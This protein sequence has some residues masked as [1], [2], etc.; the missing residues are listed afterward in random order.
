MSA[1]LNDEVRKFIDGVHPAVLATIN[2]DGGPQTS[3]VW[4]MRDG[5]DL[6]ISTT[7]GLRKDKNLRRDPRASVLVLSSENDELYVEIRGTATVTE[8]E[9]RVVAQALAEI[10]EGEGAGQEYADL[11]PE[12]IRT[13][14]RITP[15]K[16]NAR[17][18]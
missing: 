8:D 17:L 1:K 11:P 14:I 6:L 3:V 16:V 7:A 4:V 12:V 9:G 10:Y 13:V 5:D 2:P 18:G 15:T